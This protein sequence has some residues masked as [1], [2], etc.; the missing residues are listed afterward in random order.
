MAGIEEFTVELAPPARAFG[1]CIRMPDKEKDQKKAEELAAQKEK[2]KLKREEAA[3]AL[4]RQPR[5]W[6]DASSKFR[7][8]AK[9]RGMVSKVVKLELENGSVISVPLEKLSDDDQE[10]IR[11]RKY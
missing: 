7:V 8:T 5:T 9:F 10:C 6:T 4:V 2:E 1:A 11:E 3:K